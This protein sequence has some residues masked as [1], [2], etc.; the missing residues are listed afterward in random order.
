MSNAAQ[1]VRAIRVSRLFLTRF[2]KFCE[3]VKKNGYETHF[4]QSSESKRR[5]QQVVNG[6]RSENIPCP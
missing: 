5:R 3:V 1:T 6:K 2:S 4:Q